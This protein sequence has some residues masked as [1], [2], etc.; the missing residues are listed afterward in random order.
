[1]QT[2]SEFSAHRLAMLEQTVREQNE[3]LNALVARLSFMANREQELRV[4]LQV[5]H[6][7]LLRRDTDFPALQSSWGPGTAVDLAHRDRIIR[8]LQAALDE[9]T[10]LA[11]SLSAEITQH[12]QRIRELETRLNRIHRRLPVRLYRAARG[13]LRSGTLYP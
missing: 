4:L 13:V 12:Q 2:E 8:D 3:H 6:G 1:M 5:A 7:E 10:A 9:Q 11:N